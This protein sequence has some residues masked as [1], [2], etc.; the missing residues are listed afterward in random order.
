MYIYIYIYIYI[1]IQLQHTQYVAQQIR[2]DIRCPTMSYLQCTSRR[3]LAAPRAE[4]G[5]NGMT[6]KYLA[7]DAEQ[8]G[9]PSSSTFCKGGC[10]GN[11]V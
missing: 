11:R 7:V 1:H 5:S 10:S 8:R 2:Y 3:A 9:R 4:D 6:V